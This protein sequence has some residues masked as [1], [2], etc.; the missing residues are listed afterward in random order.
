MEHLP[1]RQRS[2]EIARQTTLDT[3][4]ISPGGYIDINPED[5]TAD[6]WNRWLQ[7]WG[8]V[9]RHKIAILVTAVCGVLAATGVSLF[10]TPVYL[11]GTTLEFQT[12][13]SQQKPLEG[14]S[15]LDEADP[16]LLQT[17]VRLLTSRTL[18]DRVQSKLLQDQSEAQTPGDRQAGTVPV[19]NRLDTLRHWLGLRPIAPSPAAAIGQAV[20]GLKVTPVKES[21]IVQISTQSTLPHVAAGYV[22]TLATEF[23]QQNLEQRW[24]L[25]QTTAAWLGRAQEDLREKLEESERQLLDYASASGLVVTSKDENI[26]EQKLLEVQAEVSRA[27]ADRIAKES[28]YRTAM[29]QPAESLAEVLDQG[30]MAQYQT[31]LADLR[32]ELAD[33]AT[34]LTPAHPKVQRLEAQI[35]ELESAKSRE[36]GNIL[37]RMRTDYESAMRREQQLLAGLASQSRVLSSQDQKLI[38][39]KMLQREVETYRKLYETTLQSGKEASLASALRPVSARVIDAAGVPRAPYKPD[40]TRNLSLGLAGGLVIGVGFVLFRERTD[41][42]IRVPGSIPVYLNLRELGIIPSAAAEPDLP[43][44]AGRK[45]PKSLPAVPSLRLPTANMRRKQK[46][47][48]VELATWNRKSSQLAESFRAT[49]TSILSGQNG[50]ALQVILIASPSAQE[51]KSTVITNLAIAL[52]EINQRV[53]LIDADLRRPRLHRIFDQANAWGLSDLLRERTPCGEYPAEALARQTHIPRLSLL[54]SGPG[55]VNV[56]RLLHSARMADLLNRMR[57]DFDAV[58]IDTPPVL[59]LADAR[60]LS[61]LADAVVLVFRAGQT[62]REAAAMA[63]N[64]FEADG[65]PVLGTVLNDWNPRTMGYGYYPASYLP[66]YPDAS[67][68]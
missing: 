52:A 10:Q 65:V 38:R 28:V 48:P 60:I 45:P 12:Q 63:V 3:R 36:G 18:Q 59:Q 14:I 62:T 49:L 55:S 13:S 51:G 8:A 41:S 17:Q 32:R 56:S 33:A 31:K 6:Q 37:N 27:Q 44:L 57:E 15:F 66:Y 30:P 58:L 16:Y 64:A 9:T 1:V 39:Y 54:P 21:R 46:V 7:Y 11:A 68:L 20:G 4:P 22:N 2:G 25:Y 50:H 26:A 47:E 19:S 53:L 67:S 35:Q 5:S 23:I 40:V 42:S 34:A 29:A 43:F 24:S 61:R